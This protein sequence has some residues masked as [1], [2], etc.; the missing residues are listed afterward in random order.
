MV[1]KSKE[2]PDVK[3]I[4]FDNLVEDV[5]GLNIKGLK[6]I[7]TLF[8]RPAKYFTAAKTAEWENEYTPSFRVWFG[9]MAITTGLQFIW[10]SKTS[11][12][13]KTFLEQIAAF[14]E[15]FKRGYSHGGR[16]D[17]SHITYD[18]FDADAMTQVFLKWYFVFTPF[19]IIAWFAL[20]AFIFRAW[21][22]KLTYVVRIRYIFASI[23]T[24]SFIG[25]MW[26]LGTI[27]VPQS[28]FMF[29]NLMGMLIMIGA[30][31]YTI[32]CGAFADIETGERIG[33]TIF[34]TFIIII[35][36]MI[37][38]ITASI[39]AMFIII[40]EIMDTIVVGETEPHEP[41]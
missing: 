33:R 38:I 8:R 22:E 41:H 34:T 27:T 40:P 28:H 15:Q 24:G 9:I 6:T 11:P 17:T 13:Y 4:G 19:M 21:G 18:A 12:F 26:T 5:F 29:V 3:S 16:H 35:F 39:L 37:A 31:I 30:F 20:L 10:G 2:Q 25:L 14:P 36:Y 1:E 23:V 7:W 32:Y